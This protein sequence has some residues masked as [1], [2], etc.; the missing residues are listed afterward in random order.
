MKIAVVA[1]GR[2]S[3]PTKGH[4]KV[5]DKVIQQAK[6]VGGD[7][8]VYVSHTEDKKKNPLSYNTKVELLS[9]ATK[10]IVKKDP[11][12]KVKNIFDL[13]KFIDGKYDVVYVVAGSDRVSDYQSKLDQYNGKDFTF[14]EIHAVSAGERDP[15]ADDTS[16]ISGTKMRQFVVDGDYESFKK[17]LFV[18]AKD[19]LAKPI[20]DEIKKNLGIQ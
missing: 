14:K 9:K 4:A 2:F 8:M 18:G 12:K 3:P 7:P 13:L 19:A 11:E 6:S 20:F 16:G 10:G 5:V 17:N 1:F 15:D